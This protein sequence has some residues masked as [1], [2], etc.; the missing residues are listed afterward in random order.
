MATA[1]PS[2]NLH[3]A[4]D[5]VA[6]VKPFSEAC[7]RNQ[8]P[9]ATEL[10]EL[11]AP[12]RSVLEIGSGTGQHSVFIGA[13]LPHLIWQTT[14]LADNHAGIRAWI[15]EADLPNV[16]PPVLLDVT[17]RPWPIKYADAVFSANT[18][19]IVSMPAVESMFAGI[20]EVLT[21]GGMFCSYG[22]YTYDGKHTSESNV[23]FEG[24]LK[25]RDPRSGV[26]DIADLKRLADLGDIDLEGDR[27]MPANN[28][29]LVW[30]K[31]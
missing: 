20:A 15:N 4:G 22:P 13:R 29:L 23:R 19:H 30:R 26:R 12:C 1:K 10:R 7:E 17:A 11:F 18:I 3:A 5:F 14:D 25:Q 6:C 27:E 28:R 24:W 2:W 31:R 8:A 21:S 16:K 9:I